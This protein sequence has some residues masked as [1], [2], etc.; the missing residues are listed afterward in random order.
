MLKNNEYTVIYINSYKDV[1]PFGH[2]LADFLSEYGMRIFIHKLPILQPLY[3]Y[4][5]MWF[6]T[7]DQALFA[8]PWAN[9]NNIAI[10]ENEYKHLKASKN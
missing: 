5:A 4:T 2:R 1:K 9:R 8:S 10:S 6:R 7:N 3:H